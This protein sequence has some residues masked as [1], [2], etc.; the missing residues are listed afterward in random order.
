MIKPRKLDLI[1]LGNKIIYIHRDIC[2]NIIIE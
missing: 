2:M 1:C